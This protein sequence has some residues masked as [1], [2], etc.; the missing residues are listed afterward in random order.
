MDTYIEAFKITKEKKSYSEDCTSKEIQ[1]KI[2]E[3]H[4]TMSTD[5]IYNALSKSI[6]PEIHGMEDIKKALLLLL[7]IKKK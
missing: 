2:E 5:K 3:M 4:F 7:S 6:A 1:Q